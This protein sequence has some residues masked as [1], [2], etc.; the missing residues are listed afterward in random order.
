MSTANHTL[1]AETFALFMAYAHDA[2][3][4]GGTP[5]VG[6]NIPSSLAN[7]GHITNIKKAG[8][9]STFKDEGNMW[10][11]FTPAGVELAVANGAYR[12]AFG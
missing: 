9:A 1:T 10:M 12:P 11:Q 7:N 5:L 6:G 4:W 3:N 8:L 2:G